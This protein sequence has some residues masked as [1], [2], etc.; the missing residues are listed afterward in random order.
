MD[1]SETGKQIGEKLFELL[2]AD[3]REE[4]IQFILEMMYQQNFSASVSGFA[5]DFPNIQTDMQQPLTE[6]KEG[7]LYF[8]LE[9]RKV[10]V[11][12]QEI[13]L[14]A[15]EFDALHL[16]IANRKRVLTFET[17]SYYVWDE[18]Y[19]DVTAQAIHN[20]MSRLRQKLQIDSDTPEYIVSVRG[21]GYKFDS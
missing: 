6:I 3:Q 1:I 19:Y 21:V 18:E 4:M 12:N 7:D 10:C 8:C 15:K 20:L 17:I 5:S 2:N 9:E 11:C 14:T 16:L 13:E